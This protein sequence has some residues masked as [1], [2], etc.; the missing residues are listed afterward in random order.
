MVRLKLPE[1][2]AK[3]ES[4]RVRVNPEE[5]AALQALAQSL[6]QKPSQV[7]R[8]LVRE[9][10]TGGPEYFADELS[11]LRAAHREI[12]AV[13]RNINQLA[14]AANRDEPV[15]SR[16]LRRN[17][18]AAKQQVERVAV[19]YREAVERIQQRNADRV[20]LTTDAND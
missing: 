7:V 16:D 8:R 10:I 13:G 15:V 17:L 12:A 6:D 4:L 3:T 11:E 14:R 1:G 9:A 18:A 5:H 2:E 19:L 20:E